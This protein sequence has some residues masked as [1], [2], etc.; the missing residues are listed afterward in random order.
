[1]L[2]FGA[3]GENNAGL[4]RLGASVNYQNATNQYTP[5]HC[6]IAGNNPEAIRVLFEAGASTNI[7]NA[8]V[9]S[10]SITLFSWSVKWLLIAEWR[11]L[12]FRREASTSSSLPSRA[13]VYLKRRSSS[14]LTLWSC[15][16]SSSDESVTL[17]HSDHCRI[18]LCSEH[19]TDV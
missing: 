9:R 4:F 13:T 11:R 7:R 1:M 12:H 3:I 14:I 6:A 5:L 17:R 8:D 15:C 2:E 19:W 18:D 16:S 10:T